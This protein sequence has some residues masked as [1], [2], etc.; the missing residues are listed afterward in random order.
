M[1]GQEFLRFLIPAHKTWAAIYRVRELNQKTPD[2]H[3][4]VPFFQNCIVMETQDY[5]TFG[6]M[7]MGKE[8]W[9]ISK[10]GFYS[11]KY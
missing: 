5:F 10:I 6:T 1:L 2:D 4:I 11:L 7:K 3:R 8:V 9:L